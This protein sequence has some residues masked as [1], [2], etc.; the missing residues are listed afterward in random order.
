[1]KRRDNGKPKQKPKKSFGKIMLYV[2]TAFFAIGLL[3]LGV[4]YK[5]VSDIL[6][7][8]P[9]IEVYDINVLLSENSYIYDNQGNLIEKVED[10]GLRTVVPYEKIDEDIKKAIVAVEDKTFWEHHGF[11]Y[12]RLA[13]AV[14]ESLSSGKEPKGT[15]T[16][17]QQYAR[18][19]YLPETRFSSG[20]EGYRRKV[21][22]A[23]YAVDLEKN[24]SKEDILSAY[25]NTIEFGTNTKG[26]QAA[27]TRYFS[28]DADNIDYIEAAI[29][30]G[31][32]QANT[33]YSPFRI[34]KTQD[35]QASDYVLGE[36]SDDRSIVFNETCLDR[37]KIVLKVMY[38]NGV[39]T[40]D[41]Y[42]FAKDYDIKQ[43]LKPTPL[44][45]SELSSY[46]TDMVKKEVVQKFMD[47]KGM[48]EED[49]SNQL[50][51]GG[52]RIY[53]TM[54]SN[55]QRQL[56]LAFDGAPITMVYDNDTVN[57]VVD[58]QT[59][60]G[61]NADGIAGP[62]TIAKMVEKGFFRADEISVQSFQ[63]WQ[64]SPDVLVLKEA[65]EKRGFLYRKHPDMP[66]MYAYRDANKNI[67][68]M[69]ENQYETII[70]SSL[71]LNY[72]Y[73]IINPDGQLV[74]A[75][76]NYYL[77]GDGDIVFKKNK[78]F[79]F[80]SVLNPGSEEREIELFIKNA[81]KC[82]EAS[83]VPIY[84]ASKYYH[85]M[86]SI[87]Q[88]Y[89]Y[90][91]STVRIP[92]EYKSENADGEFVL[93]KKFLSDNPEVI[94]KGEDGTL[95]VDEE[96]YGMAT[97]G[98]IQPQA[99]MTIIDYRTGEMKA[100]AGGRNVKG[101]MIYNRA[102]NPRQPGSAIKPLGVYLPCFDNGYSPSSI[103]E[104]TPTYG[105]NGALWPKNWYN[106]YY[107]SITLR[108]AV[109]QSSNVPPVKLLRA[110][111]EEKGFDYL[112]KFGIS[113]LVEEGDVNDMNVSAIALGGMTYGAT[114]FDMTG[115]Y[116]AIAN[117]GTRKETITFT[118]IT[119]KNGNVVFEN[120]PK[121]TFI[122]NEQV[123][124]LMQDV[125]YS[126]A[127]HGFMNSMAAIRPGNVGIPMV[128]K[129]GTTSNKFDIWYCGY[130]PYYAS[131]VWI[132]S[133][134]NL[135]L[136][137]ESTTAARFWQKINKIIHEN[138]ENRN[139][140]TGAD[141][142]LIRVSV[143]GKS[144]MLPSSLS[145]QD[146]SGN[147]V[148]TD[149]YIPGN[150][151]K[152]VD[153]NRFAISMCEISG[154]IASPHCPKEERSTKIYRR[155]IEP[156]PPKAAGIPIQDQGEIIPADLMALVESLGEVSGEIQGPEG[157]DYAGLAKEGPN[158][159]YC[160]IH[161]GEDRTD[162]LTSEL[163]AGVRTSPRPGGGR[164]INQ[165]IVITRHYG[166][167]ILV[168]AGSEIFESGVIVNQDDESI[169]PWQIKSFV[170]KSG[171]DTTEPDEGNDGHEPSP[172]PEPQQPEPPG[173]EPDETPEELNNDMSEL[174]P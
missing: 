17:T 67:L 95:Y 44:K 136:S 39:I 14:V 80:Y 116:G 71:M 68:K 134:I 60:Y 88:L 129:T 146:P 19:M 125:L 70:G 173:G 5:Y 38:D 35:I 127:T 113:T 147:G 53:S 52:L 169:Y 23:Y 34:V 62:D 74:I 112:K 102:T 164:V 126:T 33:S 172:E 124:W 81:Y 84:G 57:A 24:L 7:E 115:A 21:Q 111:G 157:L 96:H 145:H 89:I 18:N 159:S 27:T 6:S 104:D 58:F 3:G 66:S 25:L 168:E 167:D 163:L 9:P 73:N 54:D 107:G 119:D 28:K 151:P 61:L 131:S 37:Y 55:I 161:T 12:V 46:F 133:D 29:L 141:L 49:A 40:K 106:A 117:G 20:A 118:K 170:I 143:D 91:G 98:I 114:N 31:I 22:E 26:I 108:K 105:E 63:L 11:N 56:D 171:A 79:N 174:T 87:P 128:G 13:G 138:Y 121:E 139:F 10:T 86:V 160:Y 162:E 142:G 99:S 15:S 85:Q 152:D 30:A 120:I 72:Y 153:N 150:Q 90:N 123:A 158:G 97:Q 50:Y 137:E 41:E 36:D 144:G 2:F 42:D 92:K 4:V 94:K 43:K 75:P 156:V 130:T 16:I 32:P 69:D 64:E 132:G 59:R 82:H 154:K 93:S 166:E 65:L 149:W 148:I 47:E 165:S 110:I 122:A 83:V 100:V 76:D 155:R 51:R 103:V 45:T 109:E 8:T 78:M 77:N 101:Q 1:M 135:G 140:K 48:S